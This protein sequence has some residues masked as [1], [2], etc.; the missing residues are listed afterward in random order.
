MVT[1]SLCTTK[2]SGTIQFKVPPVCCSAAR[3]NN[4]SCKVGEIKAGKEHMPIIRDQKVRLFLGLA[5]SN[6]WLRNKCTH[7][8]DVSMYNS[9]LA[10]HVRVMQS[11]CDSED[12][13]G[14]HRW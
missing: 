11:T 10:I 4:A 3:L 12:L 14:T 6:M 8:F 5:E 2:Y 7:A 9:K 1:V 13:N